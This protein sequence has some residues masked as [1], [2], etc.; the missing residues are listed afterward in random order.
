MYSKS[1]LSIHGQLNEFFSSFCFFINVETNFVQR[2]IWILIGGYET[3][4][5][6]F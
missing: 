6:D 2:S 3:N 4:F 1:F 5:I